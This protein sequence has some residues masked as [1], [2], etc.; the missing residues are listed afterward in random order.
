MRKRFSG[1]VVCEPRH[2]SWLTSET[3]KLLGEF[4]VARVA[5]DP[6][7]LPRG[8]EP[9]GWNGLIYYRLHGSPNMYYSKYSLDY[10]DALRNNLT[11]LGPSV[12]TW[13]I[14]D[15]TARGAATVNALALLERLQI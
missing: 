3:D 5:A 2:P 12:T 1:S 15:N 7:P 14:F 8:T 4:E 11:S 13:C 6:A 9:G 10:L